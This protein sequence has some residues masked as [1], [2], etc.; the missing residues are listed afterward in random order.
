[1]TKLAKDVTRICGRILHHSGR[2]LVVT[3]EPGDTIAF[4]ESGRRF[5]VR[6]SLER[7]YW[8]AAKWDAE[9]QARERKL[10]RKIRSAAR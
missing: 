9:E 6:A 1:M 2:N 7:L 3:L 8:V 10:A 4:R 5:T